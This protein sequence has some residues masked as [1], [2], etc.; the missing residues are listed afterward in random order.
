[1]APVYQS[2]GASTHSRASRVP[3]CHSAFKAACVIGPVS[4]FAPTEH[5][6]DKDVGRRRNCC[7]KFAGLS[8]NE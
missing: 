7:D 8:L 6:R 2:L 1:M 3:T 5:S 4:V